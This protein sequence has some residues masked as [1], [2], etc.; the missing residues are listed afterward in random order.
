MTTIAEA[1]ARARAEAFPQPIAVIRMT[2]AQYDAAMRDAS[3]VE[4][5]D[6]I[7]GVSSGQIV[8]IESPLDARQENDH[9]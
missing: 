1:I 4:Q 6:I 7:N 2:G 9:A 8:V 3:E 5:R